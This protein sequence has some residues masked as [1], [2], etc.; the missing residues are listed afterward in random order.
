MSIFSNESFAG[1]EQVVFCHDKSTGLKAI[2]A[3][4]NT[5]LGPALGGTRM[6]DYAD[7]AAALTDALRLSKGMTYKAA[8]AGLNLGGGKAVIIGDRNKLRSESYFRA[9]GRFV[10]SLNGRYI[11]AE[12]VNTDTQCME[13]IHDETDHVVGL[14]E[15]LGGTGDPSPATAHGVFMGIKA[16]LK[17]QKGSDSLSGIKIAVQGVGHVGSHLCKELAEHGA[18]LFVSDINKAAIEKVVKETKATVVNNDEIHVQDVDV[19]APCALGAIL[20]DKTLP[21]LKCSIVAGAANNQ[22]KDEKVHGS[23]LKKAGILYTPDYVINGGGLIHV[24]AELTGANK[25]YI[26]SKVD[27]IY[28]TLLAIFKTADD[29]KITNAEAA[30]KF[31]ED[32]IHKI[33][34]IKGIY[35][36]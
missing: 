25:D 10:N 5:K 36:A 6:W 13:W 1:H 30:N 21:A 20:N 18:K 16:A 28:D 29:A 2:I 23:A 19:Y 9:Y 27:G 12:D 11:T 34:Q 4:H 17:H 8:A 33:D 26:W 14:P 3:I 32:R 31:A 15:Y 35:T 22:L 24:S 7:E